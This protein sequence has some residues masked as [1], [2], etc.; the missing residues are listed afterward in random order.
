MAMHDKN[1]Y[2]TRDWQ[3]GTNRHFA[4]DRNSDS[5]FQIFNF[6]RNYERDRMRSARAFRANNDGS[7]DHYSEDGYLPSD[8]PYEGLVG[9]LNPSGEAHHVSAANKKA[10]ARIYD[11]INDHL[12][13]HSYI[14]ATAITVT[15]KN[16][17]VKLD[18]TVPDQ[19]QKQYAEEVAS[20]VR[21]VSYV[22]NKLKV[23][24]PQSKVVRN[25]AG[26]Q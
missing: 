12:L 2:Q 22:T 14:D 7:D 19:E 20:Q 17:A 6:S 23:Q 11:D 8:R 26:K 13:E 25:T 1:H 9:E 15:V 4:Y 16:G 18:G 3:D 24:K 21:G 5:D 10:D